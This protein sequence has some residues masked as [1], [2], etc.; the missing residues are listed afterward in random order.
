MEKLDNT[1]LLV[2]DT[3]SIVLL[4][5]HLI[6]KAGFTLIACKTGM[7]ALEWMKSKVPILVLLDI[8]LPDIQGDEILKKIQKM[9]DYK[10][11]PV[12]AVTAMA[13]EGDR[14]KYLNMGFSGY[15]PKPIDNVS[16]ITQ[17]KQFIKI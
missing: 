12:V 13:R 8:S 11:I 4:F 16:F 3:D 14:E 5:K 9:D 15:I 6:Q 2:E 10:G 1:I 17:I 7:E